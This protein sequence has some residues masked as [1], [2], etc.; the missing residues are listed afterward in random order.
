M[1]DPKSRKILAVVQDWVGIGKY[2]EEYRSSQLSGRTI[3]KSQIHPR[4]LDSQPLSPLGRR[5]DVKLAIM[6]TRDKYMTPCRSQ[7]VG[8]LSGSM[9][10]WSWSIFN[11][12]SVFFENDRQHL[13]CIDE[14]Q[15]IPLMI[16]IIIL[17][18]AGDTVWLDGQ[19]RV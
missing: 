3:L 19:K 10:S 6:S 7:M 8:P 12:R 4:V 14:A 17:V 13:C 2:E 9:R 18:A 16:L 5:D 15:S 1:M 11:H